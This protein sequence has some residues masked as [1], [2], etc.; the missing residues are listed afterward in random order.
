MLK[1]KNIESYLPIFNGFYGT[2]FECDC[3]SNVIESPYKYDDYEF[4]YTDYTTRVSKECVRAIETALSDIIKGITIKYQN[5]SSPREYNFRNNS[6]NVK[7]KLTDA[8]IKA[9]NTYL[10]KNFD[11]FEVYLQNNYTSGPGFISFWANDAETWINTY[12]SDGKKLDH[13]FGAT[14]DFILQNEGFDVEALYYAVSD[15]TNYI[16]AELKEGRNTQEST[17]YAIEYTRRNYMAKGIDDL[18]KEILHTCEDNIYVTF[19]LIKKAVI[20]T[21]QGIENKSLNL[22]A[23]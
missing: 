6:I 8:A 4:D 20:E 3:E 1:R 17:D 14:L 9:V 12:L 22:F 18:I 23:K 16:G 7:Y 15:E 21:I 13:A 2:H 5:I 10:L 11:M 19:D